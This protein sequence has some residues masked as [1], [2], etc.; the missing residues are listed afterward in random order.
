[1][2]IYVISN[3]IPKHAALEPAF[4]VN[5]GS[6]LKWNKL[7]TFS[8]STL[9]HTQKMVRIFQCYPRSQQ[10]KEQTKKISNLAYR[11][12]DAEIRIGDSK[13][14]RENEICAVIS[15]RPKGMYQKGYLRSLRVN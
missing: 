12:T 7:T 5:H 8:K 11:L 3:T 14:I 13:D 1:M 2:V 15:K 9:R 10:S 6:I 4:L